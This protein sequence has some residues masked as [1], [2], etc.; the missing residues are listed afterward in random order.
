[1][2]TYETINVRN[3]S[4]INQ[5]EVAEHGPNQGNAVDGVEVDRRDAR[6][7]P[8]Y[9]LVSIDLDEEVAGQPQREE[10]DG[11]AAYDLVRAEVN[12]HDACISAATPPAMSAQSRPRAQYAELVRTEHGEKCA[13]Q[14]HPLEADVHDPAAF[15]EHAADR[16]K[17]VS[18]VAKASI[19]VKSGVHETT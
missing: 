2:T 4:Q 11:G 1:M 10:V 14:H 15:G 16:R 18:G 12:R 9:A 7:R 13:G 17:H 6:N 3:V 5:I 8:R 19:A